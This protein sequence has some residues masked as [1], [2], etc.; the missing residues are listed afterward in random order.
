MSPRRSVW[1]A[2]AAASGPVGGAFFRRAARPLA[3]FLSFSFSFS[4]TRAHTK[5]SL[6]VIYVIIFFVSLLLFLFF[7]ISLRYPATATRRCC[8]ARRYTARAPYP[9]LPLAEHVSRDPRRVR[10]QHVRTRHGF[11]SAEDTRANRHYRVSRSPRPTV[12]APAPELSVVPP[13][14]LANRLLHRRPV[15]F[16]VPKRPRVYMHTRYI[17]RGIHA[18]ASGAVHGPVRC[19]TDDR[20]VS[21]A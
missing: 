7:F 4:R 5:I 8:P 1:A 18:T 11:R 15:V 9:P 10:T 14:T 3:L 21:T 2:A 16:P 6:A 17:R 20:I 12:R 13:H 19:S